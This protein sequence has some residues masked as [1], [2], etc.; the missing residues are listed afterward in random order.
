LGW[1]WVCVG[2]LSGVVGGVLSG[3]DQGFAVMM[4][5]VGV[6]E[7]GGLIWRERVSGRSWVSGFEQD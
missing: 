5:M 3:V 2:E 1:V 7:D 4:D 6:V